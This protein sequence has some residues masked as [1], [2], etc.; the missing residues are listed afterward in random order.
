MPW[1][2]GILTPRTPRSPTGGEYLPA[3]MDSGTSCLVIPGSRLG[4]K[5]DNVPF[6]DFTNL[7]DEVRPF[8]RPTGFLKFRSWSWNYPGP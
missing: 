7:W 6:D 3:I 2:T 5:L 4:G 1:R 8:P